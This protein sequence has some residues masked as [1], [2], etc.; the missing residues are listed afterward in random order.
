MWAARAGTLPPIVPRGEASDP[1]AVRS[2]T[3]CHARLLEAAVRERP[4]NWFW[5]HR[6]WKTSPDPASPSAGAAAG[7]PAGAPARAPAAREAP[8]L[9]E[10]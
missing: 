1:E 4:E 7:A 6:R 2:L 10:A 5:L 9:E 8:S 3:A